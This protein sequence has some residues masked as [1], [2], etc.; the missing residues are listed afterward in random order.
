M[1]LCGR[2][3]VLDPNPGSPLDCAGGLPSVPA[4]FSPPFSC[5]G[6]PGERFRRN[7]SGGC[8]CHDITFVRGR[9]GLTGNWQTTG[10]AGREYSKVYHSEGVNWGACYINT[11]EQIFGCVH[12]SNNPTVQP[13]NA[14]ARGHCMFGEDNLTTIWNCHTTQP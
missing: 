9:G 14:Y 6:D 8:C 13:N 11:N 5:R 7:G 4:S 2:T 3:T 1:S 12:S 10:F